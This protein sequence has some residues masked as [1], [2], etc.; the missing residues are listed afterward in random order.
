MKS[1]VSFLVN[2]IGASQ[3][4]YFLIN[5]INHSDVDAI[6]YYETMHRQMLTHKFATMQMVEAWNQNV[7]A[8]AT[9]LST[10]HK[11]LNFP[12]PP[13]KFYYVWD[14]EWQR[15][16][17]PH[18]ELYHTAMLNPNMELIARCKNHKDALENCFNREVRYIVNDFNMK[19]IED[20]IRKDEYRRTN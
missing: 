3:L 1:R 17:N 18:Y 11:L 7:P 6:V 16:H 10:A 8:I 20:V 5:E 13:L 4:S 19:E 2:N 15:P 14:L 9:S 12:G